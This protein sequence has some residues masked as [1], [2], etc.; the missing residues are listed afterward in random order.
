MMTVDLDLARASYEA[1]GQWTAPVLFAPTEITR[2][3]DATERVV[4]G[5]HR[6]GRAPTLSLPFA[7]GPRD[8]RKIDNAWWADPDLAALATDARLGEIAAA[9]LGAS[10]V[11]LWQDQLLYKPP[12]GPSETTIGWHQDWASWDTVASHAAFVTAWVAFDDV[13]D[14]NGA[15]QCIPASH[16]WGLVPGGSNFFGTDRDAQ[17]ARLGDGRVIESR[18]I[19]MRAGQVSFHHPLTFHGSGPNTS[20]RMRRSLAIHFVDAEV[21]AVSEPGMWQHYNLAL[22]LERGGRLGEC[23]RFDDLCPTVFTR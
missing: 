3:L 10:A 22:F 18:S 14:A 5:Q 11:N 2:F 13:D 6:H 23:Y 12:G 16:A 19:V 20:D 9:L 1:D 21:S 8:L 15:M 4:A 17:L 7:P